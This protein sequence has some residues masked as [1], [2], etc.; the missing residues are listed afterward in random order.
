MGKILKVI[1]AITAV[2]ALV[3][4]AGLGWLVYDAR[5]ARQIDAQ[6]VALGSSFAAGPG[7]GKRAVDSPVLCGQSAQNF[8]HILAHARHLTL[9]DRSCGGSTTAHILARSQFFQT[10]QINGVTPAARLVTVTTGG[11]DLGYLGGLWSASCAH[12]PGTVPWWLKGACKIRPAEPTA[13]KLRDLSAAMTQVAMEVH[14]RAPQATLVFVDY[15]TVLP[16]G[17]GCPDRLPLS[18]TELASAR[19]TAAA[20]ANVTEN[21]AQANHALLVR[22][23][24]LSHGH[25]VCSGKPWVFGWTFPKAL[26]R[27]SPYAY[28]P[29]QAAMQAIAY[30][31]DRQLTETQGSESPSPGSP[32]KAS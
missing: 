19:R 26:L 2:F 10:P 1:G 6:Y 22:A 7:V 27:F 14:R 9:L 32:P 4:A 3:L 8:A 21:V 15:T 5:H 17:A 20:L 24:L 13:Q 12:D 18:E 16:D 25:D 28:H 30:E 11:N 23:S 31:I 29:N